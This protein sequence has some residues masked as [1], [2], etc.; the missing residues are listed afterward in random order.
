M[1]RDIRRVE[2]VMG[3]P[4][5]LAL[6]ES[7]N[8]GELAEEVFGWL[9]W[10][11]AVFSPFRRDSQISRIA[12]GELAPAD[13]HPLVAEVIEQAMAL[14]D[15]TMGYFDPYAGGRL[16]PCGYV[17]GWAVQ[18]A[19]DL[20]LARGAYDHCVNAGGDIRACG[21]TA[22][23]RPWRIGIQDP[24]QAG[25]IRWVVEGDDLAVAT[26]GT[27]ARGG[28]VIDPFTGR[29]AAALASVT[30]IGPDL[31]LA[32]AYAT[33]ALAMGERAR[34]W[35]SGLPGHSAAVIDARGATWR[36]ADW[37]CHDEP[38]GVCA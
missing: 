3:L 13:A 18:L 10:V 38:K 28:H 6:R 7:P 17:K 37:P 19:S 12:R 23:G 8:A 30:V 25:G 33:A 26:S 5:T 35:L 9:R 34:D 32:D 31:A 4:V 2:Q 14:R 15:C 20:L 36:S 27:Y 24:W 16:D 21:V 22:S 29:A 1:A 11:D